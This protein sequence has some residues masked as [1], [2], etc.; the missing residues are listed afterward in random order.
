MLPGS[1]VSGLP[2]FRWAA[3]AA[4]CACVAPYGAES[5]PGLGGRS[6]GFRA[7]RTPLRAD[8][9]S[10]TPK[11][12]EATGCAVRDWRC[13]AWRG[14]ALHCVALRCVSFLFLARLRPLAPAA[15]A[16]APASRSV[17]RSVSPGP[18]RRAG[19]TPRR[20]SPSSGSAWPTRST[21][22]TSPSAATSPRPRGTPPKR[23]RRWDPGCWPSSS[24]WCAAPQFS[25]LFKVSGWA[26]EVTDLKMFPFSCEF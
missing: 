18:G 2:R 23:R 12:L 13:V 22:R 9:G 4:D 1:R 8:V 16:A 19:G 14:V 20:W 5:C 21:A 3:A 11:E 25:R 15:Q 26:C 17:S 6:A 10:R 24:L 7:G